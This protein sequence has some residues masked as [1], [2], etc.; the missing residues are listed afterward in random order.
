MLTPALTDQDYLQQLLAR[1]GVTPLRSAGQNFLISAEVVDA[2]MAVTDTGP[3]AV[4]ELGAGV[5]PVTVQL[6]GHGKSVR[7]IERDQTLATILAAQIPRQ[8]RA[9]LDLVTQDLKQVEWSWDQPYQIVGNIPYN[10]SG[11]IIRRLTQ[12]P[13]PPTQVVLLVQHEVGQRLAATPP[14]YHLLSLAVQLWAEVTPLV[15]VPADCFWPA[16][17]IASQLVLLTPRVDALDLPTREAIVAL[18]KLAFQQRRKQLKNTLGTARGL[19]PSQVETLLAQIGV[20]AMARPQEVSLEQWQE[21]Y[22]IV[23]RNL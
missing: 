20:P 7:A 13:Q 5:G 18:A 22:E 21:L 15:G 1:H 10:L 12:L 16:P 6:L 8:V 17:Q 14:D 19:T 23:T 4:T 2:I 3:V 9:S 11:W